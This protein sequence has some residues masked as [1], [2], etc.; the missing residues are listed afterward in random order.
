MHRWVGPYIVLAHIRPQ[1]CGLLRTSN[2]SVTVAHICRIKRVPVATPEV[3]DER[4]TKD[5]IRE[6]HE[7]VPVDDSPLIRDA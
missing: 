1:T 2:S 7:I 5:Q 4:S 3:G 6:A